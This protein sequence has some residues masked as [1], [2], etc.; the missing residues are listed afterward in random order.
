M[1]AQSVLGTSF[2]NRYEI[3]AF[4]AEPR[5]RALGAT[6]GVGNG[7]GA[8]TDLRL[9]LWQIDTSTT[10]PNLTYSAHRWHSAEFRF[11]NADQQGYWSQLMR[12]FVM[13]TTVP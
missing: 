8:S 4:A 3:M 10:D 6:A 9:G 7:F 1:N 12:T 11:T 5:C 13:P 2:L